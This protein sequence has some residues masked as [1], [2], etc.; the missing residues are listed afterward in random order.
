M[1]T[2]GDPAPDFTGDDFINASTFTLSDH[3]GDI[4]V[5][6]FLAGG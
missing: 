3:A 6:G 1:P 5:L 2:I 4:I